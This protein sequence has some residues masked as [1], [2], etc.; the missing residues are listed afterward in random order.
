MFTSCILA[1]DMAEH[2]RHLINMKETTKKMIQKN[3]YS[4]LNSMDL[5]PWSV[6]S[7]D[8]SN[9]C[10]EYETTVQWVS[11]LMDEFFNQGDREKELGIEVKKKIIP[12]L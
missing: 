9:V 7:A 8:I 5:L 10:K 11:V 2:A 1:T 12:R 3:D 6:H 4:Q